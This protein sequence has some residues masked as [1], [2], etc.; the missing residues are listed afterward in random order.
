MERFE[1]ADQ[2]RSSEK[3]MYAISNCFFLIAMLSLF[4]TIFTMTQ[5]PFYFV[6]FL[7]SLGIT[8]YIDGLTISIL[9]PMLGTAGYVVGILINVIIVVFFCVLGYFGGDKKIWPF[10]VGLL[11]YAADMVFFIMVEDMVSIFFHILVLLILPW[12]IVAVR[13]LRKAEQKLAELDEQ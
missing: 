6:Y 8:Q 1:L 10:A 9:V 11:L 13:S 4:S 7:F 3:L 5:L 12:G 2:R